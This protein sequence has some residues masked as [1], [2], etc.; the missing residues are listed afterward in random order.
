MARRV[1]AAIA[2]DLG[3]HDLIEVSAKVLSLHDMHGKTDKPKRAR[4]EYRRHGREL[5]SLL[6]VWPWTHAELGKLPK[7]WR[8]D[9]A[10]VDPLRAWQERAVAALEHEIARCRWASQH[11]HVLHSSDLLKVPPEGSAR[12]PT[13]ERP[14]SE[15]VRR[16][17]REVQERDEGIRAL[18]A[19]VEADDK[20]RKAREQA[21]KARRPVG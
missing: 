4:D 9:A 17:A 21:R 5:L 2:F 11:G 19:L 12:P 7:T 10:F 16:S 1:D 13:P 20:R 15:A 8:T 14:S 3:D 18:D 6:G